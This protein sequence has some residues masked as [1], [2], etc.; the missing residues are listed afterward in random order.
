[1]VI[2]ESPERK[3]SRQRLGR[4]IRK[5]RRAAQ[6]LGPLT[7]EQITAEVAAVRTPRARRAIHW[8]GEEGERVRLKQQRL[9]HRIAR[10][11]HLVQPRSAPQSLAGT[12]TRRSLGRDR[13]V[14]GEARLGWSVRG[15]R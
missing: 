1:M 12:N 8:D 11:S 14:R 2:L 4:M 3:A 5:L 13:G 6:E 7:P 15:E 9:R 10:D